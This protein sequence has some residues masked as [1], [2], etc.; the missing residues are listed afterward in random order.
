M[1]KVTI[2]FTFEGLSSV[3][4]LFYQLLD[5]TLPLW[6]SPG[7]WLAMVHSR[8]CSY[9]HTVGPG[10]EDES[11]LWVRTSTS[12]FTAILRA[13][14]SLFP[15]PSPVTSFLSPPIS[16][17]I[18]VALA[19]NQTKPLSLLT[20]AIKPTAHT[21]LCRIWELSQRCF[22]PFRQKPRTAKK[23]FFLNEQG[24]RVQAA[25]NQLTRKTPRRYN[26]QKQPRQWPG[27]DKFA[28]YTYVPWQDPLRLF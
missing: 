14:W 13:V 26:M 17:V 3:W 22:T 21:S 5:E 18:P 20:E 6:S 2:F 16:T 15:P 1:V 25:S 24:P 11:S 23:N 4:F 10:N 7:S 27:C 28:M 9:T 8:R 19:F 12:P